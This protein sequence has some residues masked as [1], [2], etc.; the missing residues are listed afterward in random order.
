MGRVEYLKV[1]T[2]LVYIFMTGLLMQNA[3]RLDVPSALVEIEIC[4]V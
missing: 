1:T 4:Q 2:T 3:G